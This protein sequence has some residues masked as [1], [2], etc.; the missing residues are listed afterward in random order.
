MVMCVRGYVHGCVGG[1]FSKLLSYWS[2][3]IAVTVEGMAIPVMDRHSSRGSTSHLV[4]TSW[5]PMRWTSAKRQIV[6]VIEVEQF[7][8]TKCR[9]SPYI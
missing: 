7:R 4:L 6:E 3:F 1:Q 9:D 5:D 2:E 8:G